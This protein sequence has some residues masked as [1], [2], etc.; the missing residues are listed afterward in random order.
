MG[1]TRFTRR[2]FDHLSLMIVGVAVAGAVYYLAPSNDTRTRLSL[3]SAYVAIAFLTITLAIGPFN[4]V[5][6]VR[7]PVSIDSRRDV[8]IW[9]AIWSVIHTVV[10]LQVHMRGRMSEYFFQPGDKPLLVRIRHDIFG[11][12][13]YSGLLATLLVIILAAISND[14]SLRRLGAE[15]W[16]RIQQ[17]NYVL[18][19]ITMAHAILYQIIEKRSPP[20]AFTIGFLAATVVVL[21][22]ARAI[23]RVDPN[24]T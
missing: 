4:A 1:S 6:G 18:F 19:A 16:K 15:R 12:A 11:L 20:F 10:G 5:R 17:L 13:N 7:R 9:A 23:G 3:S 24:S 8:G 14:W 21:Q 22:T 2:L